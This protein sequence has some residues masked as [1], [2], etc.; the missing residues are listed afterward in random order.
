MG[1]K[2]YTDTKPHADTKPH[3]INLIYD[4]TNGTV[5]GQR[6]VRPMKV[7]DEL[8]FRSTVGPVHVM[9]SPADVFGVTE[10]KTD[11]PALVVKKRAPF[12]YWCGVQV[13]GQTIGFP[14][15]KNFGG[16]EDTSIP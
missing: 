12:Q 3:V 2:P 5:T 16:F 8:I 14:A 10:Y 6:E 1:T 15:N 13:Q 9:L 11:D 7:G 4:F